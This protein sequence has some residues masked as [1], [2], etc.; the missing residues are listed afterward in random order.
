MSDT[1]D[2]FPQH[3]AGRRKPTVAEIMIEAMTTTEPP[4]AMFQRIAELHP[5]VR[6]DDI[7]A[8]FAA[9]DAELAKRQAELESMQALQAVIDP[10]AAEP[11]KEDLTISE[12]AR[13]AAARGDEQ[14]K[15]YL[16]HF[17]SAEAEAWERDF[18]A[19]V[20]L[21]PCWEMFEDGRGATRKPGARHKTAEDLVAA[22]RANQIAHADPTVPVEE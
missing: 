15:A 21:D 20:A 6:P 10:I 17:E 8:A 1:V 11:G 14:A 18:K 5:D 7:E 12:L 2:H 22:Y 3:R 16:A 19:A 9:A 4:M 13:I